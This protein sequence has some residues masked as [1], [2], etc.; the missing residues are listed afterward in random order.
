MGHLGEALSGQAYH[1]GKREPRAKHAWTCCKFFGKVHSERGI[2]RSVLDI[3]LRP[4]IA[5]GGLGV[6]LAVRRLIFDRLGAAG[7]ALLGGGASG[8]RQC[9]CMVREWFRKHAVDGIGPAAVMFDDLV[10]YVA[11]RELASLAGGRGKRA[12]HSM[13]E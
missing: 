4:V 13:T 1:V 12:A 2:L 10:S 5:G 6:P 3:G 11:H 8:G 9:G 7:H